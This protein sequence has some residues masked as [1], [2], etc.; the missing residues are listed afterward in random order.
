MEIT[1]NR[2]FLGGVAL[3]FLLVIAIALGLTQS[4][5]VAGRPVLL[6]RENQALM[7]YLDQA[8][9]WQR[10]LQDEQTRLSSLLPAITATPKPGQLPAPQ[11]AGVSSPGDLYARS[12]LAQE[13]LDNLSRTR[14]EMDTAN[15]PLSLVSLHALA[16]N[17][18]QDH[19]TLAQEVLA[20]VGTPGEDRLRAI[21][22]KRDQAARSLAEMQTT[23]RKQREAMHASR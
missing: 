19:L 14:Q 4:P 8:E 17:A 22:G 20:Y 18:A 23:I 1:L 12:R 7:H 13:A 16:L 9:T 21:V 5:R 10:T 15:V 3:I 11:Q 2:K 6:T